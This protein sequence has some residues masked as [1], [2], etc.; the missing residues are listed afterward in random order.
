MKRAAKIGLAGGLL[1]A[2]SL[3]MA[4]NE[5]S[6][7][8]IE[9]EVKGVRIDPVA[10][11]PVVILVDKE[12][13]RALPIW[14][15]PSEAGAIERELKNVTTTRPMTHD[16]FH[17]VL[18]RLNTKVKEVKVVA[19]R[20]QTFYGTLVLLLGKASIEIDARPSDAIVL[21][22]KAGAP[23]SVATPLVESQ[24]LPLEKKLGER[25]GIRVQEL[26]PL[27]ASQFNFTGKKGVLVPEVIAGSS[28]ET[29]GV[30]AGDIITRIQAKEVGSVEEFEGAFDGVKDAKR[31]KISVFRDDKM[32]DL[33]L[34]LGP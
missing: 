18:G 25:H 23:I 24:G 26:T 12:G 4:G 11:S 5:L 2:L 16:L 32:M 34:P 13:R 19:L 29:A 17:T 22:L 30:K 3:A 27:L 6:P 20:D 8:F 21:A 1:I 9:M 15:G 31:V 33:D 28:A 7:E 14:V 10:Q